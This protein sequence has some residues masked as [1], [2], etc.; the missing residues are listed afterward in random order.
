[1]CYHLRMVKA[2][3]PPRITTEGSLSSEA[4]RILAR[5]R[6]ARDAEVEASAQSDAMRRE[7][8]RLLRPGAT[9]RSLGA[10][11]DISPERV[12]QIDREERE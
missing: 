1:M 12:A 11:L 8:I 2:G 9:V 5:Y 3:R 6:R 10:L 4:R 7:L